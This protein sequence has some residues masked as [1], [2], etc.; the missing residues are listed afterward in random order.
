LLDSGDF[1]VDIVTYRQPIRPDSGH[2][3]QN[4]V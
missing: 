1:I 4:G 3:K 2:M